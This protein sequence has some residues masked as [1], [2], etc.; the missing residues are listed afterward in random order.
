[1]QDGKQREAQNVRRAGVS[2]NTARMTRRDFFKLI[3]AHVVAFTVFSAGCR[4]DPD[5]SGNDVSAA[6]DPS[7]IPADALLEENS[8]PLL[9]EN[10]D[11]LL[12]G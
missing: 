5:N 7:G 9:A 12:T 10:G 1:M 6:T 4:N 3:G 11:Y 8:T 2:N